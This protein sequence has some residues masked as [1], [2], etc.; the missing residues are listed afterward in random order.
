MIFAWRKRIPTILTG[1]IGIHEKA[2]AIKQNVSG[3][4]FFSMVILLMICFTP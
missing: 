3:F 4:Y 2:H 1:M